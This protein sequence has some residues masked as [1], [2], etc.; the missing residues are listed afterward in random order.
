MRGVIGLSR[1][2]GVWPDQ[3]AVFQCRPEWGRVSILIILSISIEGNPLR[4]NIG[5]RFTSIS[6][7][8]QSRSLPLNQSQ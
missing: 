5:G 2:Q 6:R 1:A 7:D 4:R 8:Y 3:R